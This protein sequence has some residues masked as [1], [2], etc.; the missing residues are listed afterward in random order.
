MSVTERGGRIWAAGGLFALAI[1]GI[2]IGLIGMGGV[3]GGAAWAFVAGAL[4]AVVLVVVWARGVGARNLAIVA[5][6]VS[7]LALAGLLVTSLSYQAVSGPDH[8]DG[9]NHLVLTDYNA[10]LIPTQLPAGRFALKETATFEPCKACTDTALLAQGPT[11]VTR[12]SSVV[13][14]RESWCLSRLEIE[15]LA[16]I[17]RSAPRLSA[18]HDYEDAKA[19]VFVDRMP[20]RSILAVAGGDIEPHQEGTIESAEWE[21]RSLDR[22]IRMTYFRPPF[23]GVRPLVE[24]FMSMSDFWSKLASA[25]AG[26]ASTVLATLATVK[27]HE[28]FEKWLRRER[29]KPD[30]GP[31]YVN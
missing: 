11:T 27:V 30:D 16:R 1:L 18:P 7:V 29:K 12:T 25:F 3:S 26:L 2:V 14:K 22:T 8:E 4:G 21:P 17:V 28:P 20:V 9:H 24:P 6:G 15:P 19:L 31:Y 10:T 13:A 23:S 5:C